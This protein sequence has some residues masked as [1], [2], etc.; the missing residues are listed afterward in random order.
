M[1]RLP[2]EIDTLCTVPAEDAGPGW[3]QSLAG[4]A[5]GP[6]LLHLTLSATGRGETAEM[7]A[8]LTA[9]ARDPVS[10]HS[11]GGLFCGVTAL[12]Y[13]LRTAA[14]ADT[15]ALSSLDPYV[16]SLAFRKL[17]A[18]HGR[19]DRGELTRMEEYDL[20][21]G[22]TGIGAYLLKRDAHSTATVEI[23]RYLVR[24]TEPVRD[25]ADE[26]PGWWTW[27]SPNRETSPDF[28][29]GHANLGMA[30]G[31]SGPLALLGLAL[32]AGTEVDGH[33]TAI[34]RICKWM[35]TWRSSHNGL[36]TWPRWVTR[37]QHPTA[38]GAESNPMPLAWCYGTPG[39]ARAQQL[40]AIATGDANRTRT[41]EQALAACA[42]DPR[43]IAM[44]DGSICH[45]RA[46]LV[47]TLR[48][49]AHDDTSGLLAPLLAGLEHQV[50]AG[51][52]RGI[53]LLEGSSGKALAGLPEGLAGL[54]RW[55]SCLLVIA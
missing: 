43:L 36:A 28:P 34:D 40:A 38:S 25:G 42:A 44:A 54:I 6:C 3:S 15:P 1:N 52:C 10:S 9:A 19:I 22:L 14:G 16:E 8:W 7:R 48:R 20:I 45:G 39:Q 27:Q 26:L 53:G 35:D 49:A 13:V 24:L 23:L 50:A 46:G 41:A 29:G 4:G 32:R 12:A 31:I 21:R 37:V 11:D 18:A 33:R 55:D 30:H 51:S 5:L 17:E 47:Q 2:L